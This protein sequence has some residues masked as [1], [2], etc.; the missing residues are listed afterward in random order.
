MVNSEKE[1]LKKSSEKE[2][3]KKSSYQKLLVR[4]QNNLE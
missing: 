2:K 3:L 4:F 1:K